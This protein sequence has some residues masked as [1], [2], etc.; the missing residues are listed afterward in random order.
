MRVSSLP[1]DYEWSDKLFCELL[2]PHFSVGLSNF[3]L[4]V[5]IRLYTHSSYRPFVSYTKH[6]AKI[7]QCLIFSPSSVCV[8]V[9]SVVSDSLWPHGLRFPG[10]S[11]HGI[12]LAVILQWVAISSSS[13]W[14]R[15]SCISYIDKVDSLPLHHLGSPFTFLMVSFN[16]QKLLNLM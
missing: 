13:D 12:L 2:I 5:C 8:C 10:S 9:F 4:L 1:N 14:N 3:F 15:A 7:F 11:V 16:K 6:V